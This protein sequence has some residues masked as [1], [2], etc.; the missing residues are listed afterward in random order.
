MD[1]L[2]RVLLGLRTAPKDDLGAST[3][4]MVYGSP[5]TVPADFLAPVPEPDPNQHL[6]RLRTLAGQLAPVPTSQH[7]QVSSTV[8]N[9]LASAPYVF[10]R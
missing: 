2:P 3:A 1:E 8:P 6:Q 4:E 7:R 10:I 5:V 9:A